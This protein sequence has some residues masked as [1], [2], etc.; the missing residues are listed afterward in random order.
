VTFEDALNQTLELLRRHRRI[1]YRALKRQ[2]DADDQFIDD[3]K[4]EIVEVQRVATDE[5][6]TILVYIGTDLAEATGASLPGAEQ[7]RPAALAAEPLAVSGERRQLTVMFCDL[8]EST[9]LSTE[10]DPEDFR[11][12]L[13]AYYQASASV[14]ERFGGHIAQYLG[15][16]LL[17]YH[18]YPVAHED[19][20]IRA[21][22]AARA[23]IAA[24]EKLNTDLAARF[25]VRIGVRI[26]VHTG[27]VVVGELEGSQNA[28][29]VALGETLNVA[30]RIQS[31][32]TRN[33]V[34]VSAA[35]WRLVQGHFI[36]E[37]IGAHA[38][39]GISQPMF[40]YRIEA[41]IEAETRDR[42]A[43]GRATPIV[44]RKSEIR[45]LTERW[46]HM[47]DGHGHV[48][49]LSG[50]AGVGKSRLLAAIK[51]HVDGEGA[52]RLTFRCSPFHSNNALY[53][54]VDYMHR[55]LDF[56]RDDSVETKLEKLERGLAQFHFNSDL[57][58]CL[59]AALLSLPL[60]EDRYP[61]LQLTSAQQRQQTLETI[62][63]W[64]LE[65][66][67]RRPTLVIF[68]D[69]HW[70]DPTTVEMLQLLMEQVP[71]T[72][73]LLV[74]AFR[75]D[76]QIPWP[77]RSYFTHIVL[78]RL[79]RAQSET[80]ISDIAKGRA[81]PPEVVEQVVAKSDGVPL[82]IEELVKMILESGLLRDEEGKYVLRGPLQSLAIP[83]TLQ[84][85]LMARLDRL[86]TAR[87]IAQ[88]GAT[89]GRD[90]SYEIIRAVSE[91]DDATLTRGLNQLVAAEIVYARGRPPQ[92]TYLFK[93]ALT[94]DAAYESLLR[95]RRRLYHAKIARILEEEFGE[96]RV[97]KPDLLAYHY[98]EAGLADQAIGYW[99]QAG[100]Q[101]IE[102]SANV[103]AIAQLSKAIELVELLPNGKHRAQLALDLHVALG[104]P[105]IAVRGY[106]S[107]EVEATYGRARELSVEVGG[108]PQLA[109]IL[110]GLWVRYLTGGPIGA[111]LEMAEQYRAVAEKLED[112]GF[113]LETCQVMGI[114]LFYL[115]EFP[116]ALAQ[117]ARGGEM[118]DPAQH[119]ALVY[120][121]GGADTGVAIET[122]EALTL[123]T[124]GYP[125]RARQSMARARQ[126]AQGLSQHPFSVAFGHY[127]EGWLHKLLREKEE[128]EH[129]TALAM[130]IC[131]E[132]RFPFWGLASA[133][134]HGSTLAARG[135]GEEG[136]MAIRQALSSYEEI[137]GQLYRPELL[138]LLA[139]GLA[140]VGRV[141]EALQTIDEA[142]RA[143]EQSQ[144]RWWQ[145]ELHRLRG[146]FTLALPGDRT[147]AAET[148]FRE[149][150]DVARAQK[151]KSW[152]LRA[153]TSLAR[154]WAG[155]GKA[156]EAR[157]LL[158]E[159]HGWF[160]E[161]HDTADLREAAAM[162]TELG[163]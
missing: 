97:T 4:A 54:V 18:G 3:L 141:E 122:H 120:E 64:L 11:E 119:H 162:L 107:P 91:M 21:I 53:P 6:G 105:L 127:F 13:N 155:R 9:A 143:V 161:G 20:A 44:G 158:E 36:G 40:L 126:I 100:Q 32:A 128:T 70:A 41:E 8:I 129:T 137:G 152:E 148:A 12:V 63:S 98:S 92:A 48:V 34:V 58:L 75:P 111:A 101:A 22:H 2:F 35:T 30:S 37:E 88:L 83:T 159:I 61:P 106:A 26:G 142:L 125:D 134:L 157:R 140:G 135:G 109:N 146:E 144:D 96:T 102:R 68:E 87:D 103:E 76:F 104:V 89:I 52:A 15:D 149:A 123:W 5:G 33:S 66:A 45:L 94:R 145:A 133:A 163:A 115:G 139:D 56:R 124:L 50:E 38:L 85:S 7:P 81:L 42:A 82:F 72:T 17:V 153:A 25:R 160:S 156:A 138:G 29:R 14:I 80:V 147:S 19:D 59:L 112:S 77:T 65:R 93:H 84:D 46:A 55:A 150:L 57:A 31:L 16:G 24:I 79:S 130:R 136:V 1:S 28:D 131:D 47:Q 51:S 151:A 118:Y 73:M 78:N 113:L 90:F 121:H 154:L 74:L 117:L 60:P 49:L 110:W 23:I 86:T 10:L 95:S 67:E 69:F 43:T 114:A 71:T 116:Q 27:R 62:A 39:K 99:K 108:S 132:H